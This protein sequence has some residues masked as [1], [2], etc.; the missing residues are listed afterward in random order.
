[1]GILGPNF[2][3]HGK[4]LRQAFRFDSGISAGFFQR[5]KNLFGGD[6]ADKI[7]SGK[8]TAPESGKGAVKAAASRLIRRHNFLFRIF[9]PAVKVHPEFDSRDM[10]LHLAVEIADEFRVGGSD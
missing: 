1:M 2:V 8:W 6:V 4:N 7:V 9:W 5:R 10:V 3:G